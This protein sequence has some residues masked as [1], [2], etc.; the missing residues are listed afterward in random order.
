MWG[1][2]PP[3]V[4]HG[5]LR[6][7]AETFAFLQGLVSSVQL[8]RRI[9]HFAAWFLAPSFPP[10]SWIRSSEACTPTIYRGHALDINIK[11]LPCSP[12]PI[13]P[14]LT[15]LI[16]TFSPI[17]SSL[18]LLGEQFSVYLHLIHLRP[19]G[20]LTTSERRRQGARSK[21][22]LSPSCSPGPTCYSAYSEPNTGVVGCAYRFCS[23]PS[24]AFYNTSPKLA[25]S[26]T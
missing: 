3:G 11:S 8:P 5:E 10:A 7:A 14:F 16:L 19:R 18:R 12:Q 9:D 22:Y 23:S 25:R 26:T 20:F 2:L 21:Y 13:P 6:Q 4:K 17:H 1:S 15:F 24:L